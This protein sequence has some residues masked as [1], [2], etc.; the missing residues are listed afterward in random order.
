M[1]IMKQSRVIE[2]A[3]K[4]ME[5]MRDKLGNDQREGIE[6]TDFERHWID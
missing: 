4:V 2:A 5:K 1:S 6:Y 3:I